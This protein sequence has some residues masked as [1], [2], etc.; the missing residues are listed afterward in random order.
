MKNFKFY[1]AAVMAVVAFFAVSCGNTASIKGTVADAP[2][3]QIVIKSL[4]INHYDVLDTIRTKADGSFSYKMEIPK[5]DPEFVYMF[6]KD[7]KIASL[8]LESGDAVSVT[9]DTLGKFNVS[10]SEETM[11]LIQ[12]EK[13]L[14]DFTAHF[15]ALSDKLDSYAENSKEYAEIN[16][17]MSN[18][19]VKYYR[20]RLKYVMENSHSLTVVPVFFQMLA[21]NF[22]VFSQDTDAFHFKSIYDSLSTVYPDSRYVRSLKREADRR[23]GIMQFNARLKNAEQISYPD[24]EM[25]DVNGVK[26]KLSEVDSK[27]VLV[28]FWSVTDAEQKMF[29]LD[30]LTPIYR[31][32][33]SKG[34]E[35]YQAAID[36]DKA[37]WARTVKDQNL[38]WINV[39]DGLGADSPAVFAYNVGKLPV[40]FLISGGEI[41]N[42]VIR[43][44]KSLRRLLDR[45]L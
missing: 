24:I 20:S 30:V 43:D 19:Y 6:Y 31:D 32:Y 12:V 36:V 40:S 23:M 2:E 17:E 14:A 3:S 18:E 21:P 45:L 8:L 7:T 34:L 42:D 26:H 9:A 29:N 10:G 28:H 15:V 33:K 16:R 22:P 1:Q 38:G 25:P 5:G 4:N 37:L 35:I 13:D 41:M 44:E 27:V 39:C 11:K